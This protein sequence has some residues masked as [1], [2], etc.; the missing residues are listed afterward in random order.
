MKGKVPCEII[1][2]YILPA[3]RRELSA[4]IIKDYD[5]HQK[6]AAK[7]LGLTDAAISQY[8]SKKRGNIDL[9]GMGKEEFEI[10]ARNI[11]DGKPV[12]KE[13]CRLCKFLIS[14]RILDRIEY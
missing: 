3:I 14:N 10:S 1:T 8:I 6:D 12:E 7:L 5:M 2:W 13:I 11:V 4:V 9:G